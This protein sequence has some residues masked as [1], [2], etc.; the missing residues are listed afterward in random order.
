[1]KKFV[2]LGS[3]LLAGFSAADAQDQGGFSPKVTITP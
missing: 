3:G 2:R 1:M